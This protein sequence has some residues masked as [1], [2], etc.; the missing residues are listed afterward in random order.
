MSD[1][2]AIIR[3]WW[4]GGAKPS[5]R[6]SF[7][8][9]YHWTLAVLLGTFAV[10]DSRGGFLLSWLEREPLGWRVVPY[11]AL[12]V[13]LWQALLLPMIAPFLS[14]RLLWLAR[15]GGPS[16]MAFAMCDLLATCL[17][18]CALQVLSS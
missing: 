8:F 1:Q 9:Y 7:Y 12:G 13:V 4:N 5:R 16:F 15:K 11:G 18:Y 14:A 6:W 10:D 3:A 2:I 17:Q